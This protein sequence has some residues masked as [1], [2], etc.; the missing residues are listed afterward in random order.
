MGNP[1]LLL[2]QLVGHCIGVGNPSMPLMSEGRFPKN[3]AS[4]YEALLRRA[5]VEWSDAETWP[6]E[7]VGCL[8][9]V[10]T[11]LPTRYELWV[12]TH[13]KRHEPT[14]RAL[15]S[16][17]VRSRLFLLRGLPKSEVEEVELESVT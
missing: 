10:S 7:L 14:N 15:G 9:F 3:W 6:R 16:L 5:E 2:D 17:A 8:Y 1:R 12:R 13:G 4:E 11:I